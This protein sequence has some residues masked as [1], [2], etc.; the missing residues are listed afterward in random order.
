MGG[1]CEPGAENVSW[2]LL[3]GVKK[4]EEEASGKKGALETRKAGKI[5][6]PARRRIKRRSRRVVSAPQCSANE[7][8]P[9]RS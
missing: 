1:C 6:K 9:T 5:T 3:Q 8:W 2:K 4:G 7:G